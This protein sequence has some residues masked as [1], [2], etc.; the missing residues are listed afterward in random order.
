MKLLKKIIF[1]LSIILWIIFF[2]DV[3]FWASIE[4]LNNVKW[5][6]KVLKD[7]TDMAT[8]WE[9]VWFSFLNWFRIFFSGILVI[10]IIYAWIQMIMSMWTDD[11]S[12]SKAKRSLWYAIIWMIFI[13]FPAEIYGYINGKSSNLFL[14]L[15][16]FSRW[17]LKN[18]LLWLEILIWWIA[19]FILVYEWISLILKSKDSDALSKAKTRILWVIIWLIFLAFIELWRQ[20]LQSWDIKIASGIFSS[21]ANLVLYIAWPVA[22]FFISLAWY[23]YIFSGWDEDKAKKWKHIIINTCIWIVLILCIYILLNDINLLKF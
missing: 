22:L 12:L 19:V 1:W 6:V 5:W 18:L 16:T 17:F 15:E 21:F 13:N 2:W 20:F 3:A 23:Y 8:V 4:W 9:T 7:W 14:S 10:F 11:D